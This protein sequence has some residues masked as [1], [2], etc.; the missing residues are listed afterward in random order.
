MRVVNKESAEKCGALKKRIDV[1][2]D[3]L[4]SLNAKEVKTK[5]IL[6][7][8]KGVFTADEEHNE[9][10]F[11]PFDKSGGLGTP[12]RVCD[13][14]KVLNRCDYDGDG[15]CLLVQFKDDNGKER[16]EFIP[17]E[18][19]KGSTTTA[20]QFLSWGFNLVLMNENANGQLSE[21]L[22]YSRMNAQRLRL[23]PK[24]GW[25]EQDGKYAYVLP[26]RVI[27]D[28]G[29]AVSYRGQC[30]E[31]EWIKCNGSL[32]GWR[33]TV[34]VPCMAS[35]RC[36]FAISTVFAGPLLDVAKDYVE[37]GFF[38]FKGYSS[39]GKTLLL[40]VASTVMGY[41]EKM[42][43]WNG[44]RAGHEQA[45]PL[46][47]D[48]TR[49][50]D[51]LGA[52]ADTKMIP[53]LIYNMVNGSS[54]KKGTTKNQPQKMLQWRCLGLSTG[55]TDL[56]GISTERGINV[57]TG[58][59][60]RFAS[61][62]AAANKKFRTFERIP[63]GYESKGMEAFINDLRG[64]MAAHHGSVF[65]E[66][67]KELAKERNTREEELRTAVCSFIDEFCARAMTGEK[68]EH[69]TATRRTCKRFALVAAAGE[70]AT[71]GI[72]G[73]MIGKNL[74][75]WNRGTA[76]ESALVCFKDWAE[77]FGAGGIPKEE[78]KIIQNALKVLTEQVG[79]FT[80]KNNETHL[81]PRKVIGYFDPAT[82]EAGMT[83]YVAA[84]PYREYFCRGI[85]Q[86]TVD[87]VLEK[88]GILIGKNKTTHVTAVG[89]SVRLRVLKV[90]EDLL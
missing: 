56:Q 24:P 55:E 49:F 66:Y 26:G 33:E 70:L 75:G 65:I 67:L 17:C 9:I 42:D 11:A 45:M 69:D 90:P 40:Q 86:K 63:A 87:A 80:P 37:S 57:K 61:I 25:F 73:L 84:G 6:A 21:Y 43:S 3:T 29:T 18:D 53:E 2:T 78:Q 51:E 20:K 8:N 1:L 10:C 14:I 79:S 12:V 77:G 83:F 88:V 31:L 22:Y 39:S 48:S 74:T 81:M 47:N 16:K 32:E 34:S 28:V 44:S 82:D 23:A 36:V 59:E 50:I 89:K 7:P 30:D 15:N 35:M 13:F 52:L 19:L 68:Y 4:N 5:E 64:S 46:Y 58:Q 38:H 85:N 76:T 60:I 71:E 41:K 62:N 54:K 72:N 27:G